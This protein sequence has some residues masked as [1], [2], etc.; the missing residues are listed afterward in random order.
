MGEA[1]LV[2]TA[3]GLEPGGPGW[4]VVN[5]RDTAWW[6]SDAFGASC[7][8]EGSEE[9]GARFPQLGINIHVLE[10]GKP[11]CMY[12][13]ESGQEAFLVL[14]GECLLLVD[15][16]ERRLRA[17]DFV[18]FPAWTEH[19]LVGAGDGPCA[20]LMVGARPDVDEVSYPVSE[21][22]VSHGAGV[23]E[24]TPD[25]GVA[26]ARFPKWSRRRHEPAGLPW[27]QP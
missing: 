21:L 1:R 12:H 25:P 23:E 19:V 5:V 26:Y 20:V 4:F 16:Q 18:H 8:F 14:S 27:Q 17:W 6:Q 3:G 13:G 15:G 2:D 11:N 10:P 22:A 9:A 7:P 24:A